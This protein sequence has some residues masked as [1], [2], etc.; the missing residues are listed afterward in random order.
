MCGI[1]ALYNLKVRASSSENEIKFNNVIK[2]IFHRGPD[3]VNTLRPSSHLLIGHTR[4]SINGLSNGSQP[5]VNNQSVSCVNGEIY[6][7][8]DLKST[9]LSSDFTTESDCELV[10]LMG[11]NLELI[12]SIHGMYSYIYYDK[13]EDKLY[14]GRDAYGEKPLYY[15]LFDD[16]ILICSEQRAIIKFLGLKISDICPHAISEYMLLGYICKDR[17]LF[18]SIKC[19]LNNCIYTISTRDSLK[20]RNV[21]RPIIAEYDFAKVFNKH[22][23]NSTNSEVPLSLALSGGIDSTYLACK[24]KDKID[25]SY[26]V[27]YASSGGSDEIDEA[28]Q[29]AKS[30]GIKNKSIILNDDDIPLLFRKQVCA[31]DAPVLDFAGIGY[32]SIFEAVRNDSFKVCLL[33]HGVMN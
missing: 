29:I 8:Y 30:T 10:G 23:D 18:S 17:T 25:T 24:L 20:E 2:N 15:A 14:F 22:V 33:G 21:K 1:A 13:N 12:H 32:Y 11:N 5:F 26:T 9:F 28:K 4:L 16:Y 19:A 6:N 31:K 7:Y 3:E 27:G